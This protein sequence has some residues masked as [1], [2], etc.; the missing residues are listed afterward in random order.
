MSLKINKHESTQKSVMFLC[1]CSKRNRFG[2]LGKQVSHSQV[3]ST[4]TFVLVYKE[5]ILCD[6]FN[7]KM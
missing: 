7:L 5:E 2:Q 4:V 1:Q 6:I 3:H